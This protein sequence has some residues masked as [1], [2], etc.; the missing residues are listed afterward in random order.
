M[1]VLHRCKAIHIGSGKCALDL[2]RIQDHL[3]NGIPSLR[4]LYIETKFSGDMD[5]RSS[6]RLEAIIDTH[7]DNVFSQY[8]LGD[9]QFRSLRRLS[10]RGSVNDVYHI[11]EHFS[12][13]TEFNFSISHQEALSIDAA[14]G[15]GPSARP[16]LENLSLNSESD[17]FMPDFTCLWERFRLPS[18]KNLMID[19]IGLDEEEEGRVWASFYS[20]IRRSPP[21]LENLELIFVNVGIPEAQLNDVLLCLPALRFLS[22]TFY[23][24]P[25]IGATMPLFWQHLRESERPLDNTQSEG[26][27]SAYPSRNYSSVRPRVCPLLV[28]L[29]V[30]TNESIGHRLDDV[31]GFI[32]S[33]CSPSYDDFYSSTFPLPGI[34]GRVLEAIVNE[35][36]F[37]LDEFLQYP[38]IDECLRNGLKA[39]FGG[40]TQLVAGCEFSGFLTC[41]YALVA[42]ANLQS[43]AHCRR[44]NFT[45]FLPL[46]CRTEI[47]ILTDSHM[48]LK[49]ALLHCDRIISQAICL[50]YPRMH[51]SEHFGLECSNL[52]I[53]LSRLFFLPYKHS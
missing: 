25:E 17:Q 30:S 9:M 22:L 42:N 39:S 1:P 33:R 24:V 48:K 4:E 32:V 49:L 28:D 31:A 46:I 27:P 35:C 18:L 13:L 38:G 5:L 15:A 52:R 41:V 37:T 14:L 40:L 50:E 44:I 43:N 12:S 16:A 51:Y 19:L 6:S 7:G 23:G 20:F 3:V 36:D 21:P 29:Y 45:M 53:S 10:A 2:R 8:R 26:I 34:K 11:L 47:Y